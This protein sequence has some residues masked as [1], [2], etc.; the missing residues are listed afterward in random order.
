MLEKMNENMLF[1]KVW[2]ISVFLFVIVFGVFAFFF[3]NSLI[4]YIVILIWNICFYE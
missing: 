1:V 3:G 4:I 2:L